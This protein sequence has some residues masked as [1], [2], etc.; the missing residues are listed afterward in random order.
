MDEDEDMDSCSSSDEESDLQS[1]ELI[2]S[3]LEKDRASTCDTSSQCSGSSTRTTSL[4]SASNVSRIEIALALNRLHEEKLKRL[5]NILVE[6]LHSCREKLSEVQGLVAPAEGRHNNGRSGEQIVI[7]H[8]GRPYFKDQ[9]F[10]PAPENS[11]TILM[12]KS[13]I[14]DVAHASS[15]PG[16][17]V[18]DKRNFIAELL[19][20]TKIMKKK[21]LHSLIAKHNRELAAGT[22]SKK[23]I[24][25]HEAKMK[26][27]HKVIENID[28]KTLAEIALPINEEYDWELISANIGGRHT[29]QEYKALWKLFLHPSIN[30]SSWSKTE[31]LK[32]KK[33]A[34][35]HNLQ[36]WDAIAKE[37]NTGRSG[38]QCFVYYKTNMNDSSVGKK[39]T[40]DEEEYLQRLVDYYRLDNYIPWSKIAPKMPNRTKLQIY[41]KY[42]RTHEKR[43]RFL[44]EED[45]VL[46]TCVDKYGLDFKKISHFVNGRTMQQLRNRYFILQKCNRMTA[47]WTI[48]E[49]K[50]LLQFMGNKESGL[51]Y[52]ELVKHFPGKDRTNIRS[53]YMTLV[54]W[55]ETNPKKDIA[56]APRRGARRLAHGKAAPDLSHA[57]KKLKMRMET[58][59]QS[60]CKGKRVTEKSSE[61]AI[62]DAIVL[63]LVNEN[64]QAQEHQPECA[65]VEAPSNNLNS[66][67][68]KKIL[69]LLNARL[70]K[71]AF[72]KQPNLVKKYPALLDSEKEVS[73]MKVRSYS[74]DI[75]TSPN[76]V[77]EEPSTPDIWGTV[78]RDQGHYVL[79]PNLPTI[80]GC[81]RLM[82]YVN[83][84]L[85][86]GKGEKRVPLYRNPFIKDQWQIFVD[87]FQAVFM[88]PMLL[89]NQHPQFS[90]SNRQTLSSV[91]KP[92]M[93]Y[94]DD[95]GI[96]SSESRRKKRKENKK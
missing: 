65:V 54:K 44:P 26:E 51:N 33:I 41:N 94:C 47:V 53:R 91:Y 11:D 48:E 10:F 52:A 83:D 73:L 61:E 85:I 74:K 66:T 55:M 22:V 86:E 37:L 93:N 25:A 2:N 82:A 71:E 50:K 62:E 1:I 58:E 56:N 46:L 89:S 64:Y 19:N 57:I 39:W 23:A 75:T 67:N 49:D 96:S 40:P 21:E 76:V 5:E 30:K 95:G 29:P 59:F 27:A 43:G 16:W 69:L 70:D 36:S 42:M 35:A 77:Q 15:V 90:D 84:N 18:K 13:S 14:F 79:P 38:Y 7:I 17:T 78:T 12:R 6:R 68:L 81:K 3:I 31:H 8:C 28:K 60:S 72:M 24:K 63:A 34:A 20:Q 87:R 80:L 92:S 4:G 88:W 9:N 32:L 45:S